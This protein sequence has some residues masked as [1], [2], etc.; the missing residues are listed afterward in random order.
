M[1]LVLITELFGTRMEI[2]SNPNFIGKIPTYTDAETPHSSG[3]YS[4]MLLD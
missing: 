3:K 2:A 1:T 4:M